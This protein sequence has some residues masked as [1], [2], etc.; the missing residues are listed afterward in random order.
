MNGEPLP[1]EHGFPARLIVPGLYGYVSATKWLR[2]IEL[3][4]FDAF[5]A[6]LGAAGLGRRCADQDPEPD[7][8]AQ[9]PRQARRPARV[10]IAGVAWAQTRGI[11]HVEVQID[12]GDWM[13]ADAGGEART[14]TPGDSGSTGW[15][16]APGRHTIAV[17]A[18]DGERRD[19]DRRPRSEP[20]PDGATGQHQIVVIV[21]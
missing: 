4:T 13:E 16:A 5:D 3:T 20:I 2:E 8:H 11:E 1:L 17:R 12:D 19:P 18:T 15:D 6:V 21:E 10:A 9:G 14:P 7:R